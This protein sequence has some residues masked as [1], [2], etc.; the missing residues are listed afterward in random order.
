MW[1]S[2][3]VVPHY[4]GGHVLPQAFRLKLPLVRQRD[5][6]ALQPLCFHVGRWRPKNL[7]VLQNNVRGCV[8]ATIKQILKLRCNL[9]CFSG[10]Y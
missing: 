7:F 10:K 3:L 1:D 8:K 5:G 2:Y 6:A 9:L 4:G